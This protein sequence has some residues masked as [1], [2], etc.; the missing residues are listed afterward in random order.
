MPKLIFVDECGCVSLLS[1]RHLTTTI[2]VFL[3]NVPV[4]F[5]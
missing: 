4:L 5:V 2:D 3:C 1:G